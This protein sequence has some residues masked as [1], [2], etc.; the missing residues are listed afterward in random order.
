[1]S[2]VERFEV[3]VPDDVGTTV[4]QAARLQRQAEAERLEIEIRQSQRDAGLDLGRVRAR[5]ADLSQR[6][7][8]VRA[9]TAELGARAAQDRCHLH[10]LRGQLQQ[11]VHALQTSLDAARQESMAL[12]QTGQAA[13]DAVSLA[14]ER[15]AGALNDLKACDPELED[16]LAR[17]HEIRRE[18]ALLDA[19]AR[20]GVPVLMT[21]MAMEQNGYTLVETVDTE[22][23]VAY[24][25]SQDQQHRI[26]V[27]CQSAEAPR[28]EA[29]TLS[30][31]ALGEEC[32]GILEDFQLGLEGT[33]LARVE[34]KSR[35]Y[36][37]RDGQTGIPVRRPTSGRNRRRARLPED[38]R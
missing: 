21:L 14:A 4:V 22:G 19:D 17:L 9:L 27:R 8:C 23:W 6:E 13:L 34:L 20:L 2:T 35:L 36:P 25:E 18:L 26:A 10:E 32:L 15:S 30:D 31:Q 5:L 38:T 33:G 3:H 28:I 37:K 1:M 11:A 29:E 12:R 24:F 7:A 16:R